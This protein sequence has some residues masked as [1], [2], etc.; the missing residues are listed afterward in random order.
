MDEGRV[1]ELL[2]RN[3]VLAEENNRMLRSMRRRA[4]WGGVM[5]LIWW[6]AIIG[7]PIVLYWL[8][9]APIVE[10]VQGTYAQIGEGV[11]DLQG[12]GKNLQNLQNLET[13]PEP[14][15]SIVQSFI[16]KNP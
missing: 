13:L 5:S 9:L 16:E 15:R 2:K 10:Q 6:A 4:F 7:V 1:E 14:L 3:L 8:Y 12:L 11:A